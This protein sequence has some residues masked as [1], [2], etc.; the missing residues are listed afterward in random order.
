MCLYGLLE[1]I[2]PIARDD[3]GDPAT[4]SVERTMDFLRHYQRYLTGRVER[5]SIHPL[6]L[7]FVRMV[8]ALGNALQQ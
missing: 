1:Q 5:S 6:R 8:V 7:S 3:D 4:E 2:M